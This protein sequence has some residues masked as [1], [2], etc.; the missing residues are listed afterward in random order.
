MGFGYGVAEASLGRRVPLPALTWGA[1][2]LAVARTAAAVVPIL[3]GKATGT[4][5]S[6]TMKRT[7]A[8]D[9]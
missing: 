3:A 4:I 7:S 2:W 6:T 5:G 9:K 8:A 1:F